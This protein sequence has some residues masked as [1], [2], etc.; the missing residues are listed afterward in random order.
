MKKLIWF[1]AI[2]AIVATIS[3]S[4]DDQV[5]PKQ[6]I[7]TATTPDSL[8]IIATINVP[9]GFE[10]GST[11]LGVLDTVT[12]YSKGIIN[13]PTSSNVITLVLQKTDTKNLYNQKV[14]MGITV[15]GYDAAKQFHTWETVVYGIKL[16]KNL[17]FT[18]NLTF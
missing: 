8:K 7:T 18:F 11:A 2:V 14:K 16:D 4:K 3:C 1:F 6:T 15:M 17:T 12:N 5:T 9:Q 13:D 10:I